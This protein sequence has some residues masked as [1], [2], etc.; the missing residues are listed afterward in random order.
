M[1]PRLVVI[2]GASPGQGAAGRVRCAQPPYPLAPAA[3]LCRVQCEEKQ[4]NIEA[5][6]AI[7]KL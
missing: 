5:N 1:L 4:Y 7:L 2:G 3:A 6:L